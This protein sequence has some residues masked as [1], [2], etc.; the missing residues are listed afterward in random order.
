MDVDVDGGGGEGDLK[1]AYTGKIL[2]IL[3]G[4]VMSTGVMSKGGVIGSKD[5]SAGQKIGEGQLEIL[6]R[7][8]VSVFE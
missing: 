1:E 7:K 8:G 3:P 6:G 4:G 2:Y 5:D